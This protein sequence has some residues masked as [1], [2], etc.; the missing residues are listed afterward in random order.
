MKAIAFCMLV[1]HTR[2]WPPRASQGTLK[3]SIIQMRCGVPQ[4][5]VARVDTNECALLQLEVTRLSICHD[6]PRGLHFAA[7]LRQTL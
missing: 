5:S 2:T 3:F 6:N 1:R 7:A 4:V